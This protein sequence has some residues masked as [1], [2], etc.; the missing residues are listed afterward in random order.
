MLKGA[1]TLLGLPLLE[2]MS[3]MARAAGAGAPPVRTAFMFWPNGVN[4][5]HWTPK[6]KGSSFEL[7][8]ILQPLAEHRDDIIVLSGLKN[9]AS[10]TGDGHYV[11]CS[12][13]L[14]GTTINK[15]TGKD[16]NAGNIS[17]D[18]LIAKQI[19]GGSVLPSLELGIDPVTTGVDT[20]VNYTRVYGSHIAWSSP[21]NP[22][23][24]EINP[25]LA[26]DRLFRKKNRDAGSASDDKSVLDLVL[27]DA[28]DLHRSLG[29]ADQQKLDQYLDS[30]RAVERRIANDEKGLS[31]GNVDPAAL[32]QVKKLDAKISKAF[33]GIDL[34]RQL[35]SRP[36]FDHTEHVRLMLDIM[37]LAFWT[38]STRVSSFMFGNAVS[39][40]NFSFLDGVKGGFHEISHHQN[41]AGQ[42]EQYKRINIWHTQQFAYFLSRLKG[43]EENGKPLLHNTQIMWGSALRDGNKHQPENLPTVLAG[44][45]GGKLRTGRHLVSDPGTPLCN[46]YVSMIEN[47]GAKGSK[48]ADSTGSLRGL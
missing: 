48:F 11:K 43:I 33:G 45:A 16:L 2:A 41:K 3:T 28:K 21:T 1:G 25:R 44:Q 19:G 6:G 38:D 17:V 47:A 29:K 10:N 15:T 23:P 34:E 37:A 35:G 7:S 40:K 12:G 20:N 36:R 14:T 42:M 27:E 8:P 13:W 31:A 5:N 39:G 46:A 4:P 30:V 22:V 24:C 32:E 26:F 9:K 18:Q